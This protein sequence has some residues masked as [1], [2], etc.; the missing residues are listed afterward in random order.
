MDKA[1]AFMP[2]ED[3]VRYSA[4]TGQSLFY[5]GEKDLR[6]KILAVARGGGRGARQLRAQAPAERGRGLHRLHRQGPG[7]GQAG[8]A[9]VPRDGAGD[10]VPH[11]D[12]GADLRGAAEPLPGADGGREPRSR[13]APSRPTSASRR[14]SRGFLEE[15]ETAKLIEL[16][17]DVQRLLRPLLVI[18]PQRARADVPRRADA[19]RG[20][21]T[22]ST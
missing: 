14:P 4:M 3:C 1:L 19:G 9:R 22:R 8:D 15:L 20:A 7:H 12:G 10:A 21:I 16:H 6:H 11:L 5:M 18:N 2:E 17:Q 13:R